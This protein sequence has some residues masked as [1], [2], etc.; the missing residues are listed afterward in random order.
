M[1][2]VF[3]IEFLP[4]PSLNYDLIGRQQTKTTHRALRLT[5]R[6]SRREI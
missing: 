6:F 4:I 2:R 1:K 5:T 3:A